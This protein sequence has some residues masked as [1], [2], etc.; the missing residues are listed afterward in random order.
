MQDRLLSASLLRNWHDESCWKTVVEAAQSRN[1]W[2][3]FSALTMIPYF[4][5]SPE[6]S[7]A[8]LLNGLRDQDLS[9]RMAASAGLINMGDVAAI[10]AL[11]AAIATETNLYTA[12]PCR[13]SRAEQA[14]SLPEAHNQRLAPFPS[15]DQ[16]R[17]ARNGPFQNSPS[18]LP[19]MM[20]GA[21]VIGQ[22]TADEPNWLTPARTVSLV[23]STRTPPGKA[24]RDLIANR[25]LSPTGQRI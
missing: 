14:V 6:L 24:R 7:R 21:K 12:N 2:V 22:T 3:R 11:E 20:R 17:V 4:K 10:P 1:S 15:S 5:T 23:E 19:G 8:F 9:V 25:A 13:S 16:V 18:F